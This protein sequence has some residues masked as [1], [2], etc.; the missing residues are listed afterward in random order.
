MVRFCQVAPPSAEYTP[1]G[2]LVASSNFPMAQSVWPPSGVHKEYRSGAYERA[3]GV[4]TF[5]QDTPPLVDL[6]KLRRSLAGKSADQLRGP[7]TLRWPRL[8]DF[9]GLQQGKCAVASRCAFG[10]LLG[11]PN[12]LTF[13]L[14][15]RPTPRCR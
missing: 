9:A 6:S 10:W 14:R 3:N 12:L 15:R 13:P 4:A 2:M 11:L 1:A 7:V 8:R 5:T